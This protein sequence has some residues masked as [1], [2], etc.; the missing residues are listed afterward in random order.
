MAPVKHRGG[1]KRL[2]PEKKGRT[3][4]K[5]LPSRSKPF[6]RHCHQD[7]DLVSSDRECDR[8]VH[9]KHSFGRI[10]GQRKLREHSSYSFA[11]PSVSNLHSPSCTVAMSSFSLRPWATVACSKQHQIRVKGVAFGSNTLNTPPINSNALFWIR[12]ILSV[13]SGDALKAI[14]DPRPSPVMSG[15]C[16]EKKCT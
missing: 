8:I 11:K 2:M 6:Y 16:I 13:L 4:R 14:F 10:Q 7:Y 15:E 1:F 9:H 3:V 5:I 12:R